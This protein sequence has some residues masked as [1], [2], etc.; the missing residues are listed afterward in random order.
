MPEPATLLMV[1]PVLDAFSVPS[2]VSV[3][4]PPIARVPPLVAMVS[5]PVDWKVAP[6]FNDTVPDPIV[7]VPA[8]TVA[9]VEPLFAA[10]RLNVEVDSDPLSSAN[11]PSSGDGTA[12]SDRAVPPVP[13]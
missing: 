12:Q 1:A 5:V 10:V 11:A 3:V 6:P 13:G 4:P 9:S 8:E 7:S 2:I